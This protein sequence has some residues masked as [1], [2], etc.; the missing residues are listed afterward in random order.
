MEI[1]I[2]DVSFASELE[3]IDKI[4]MSVPWTKGMFLNELENEKTCYIGAFVDGELVG[5][6][7]MWLVCGEAQI[8]NIAV[9]PEYRGRG[10]GNKIV[11]QLIANAKAC[12][13]ISLEVREGNL[14]A[15][16]LYEKNGF[17]KDGVR[18]NYY[19]NP[20]EDAILMSKK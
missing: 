3:N 11:E 4:C 18:K 8:T 9:L 1:K 5:Y 16:R 2:L 19:K 15:I 17:T 6:G 12:E 7:G 10:I 20:T 13:V 14:N